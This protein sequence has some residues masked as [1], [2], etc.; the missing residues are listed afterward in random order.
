MAAQENPEKRKLHMV[1]IQ[2]AWPEWMDL[3]TLSRYCCASTRTLRE[4]VNL[5]DNPLPA[6]RIRGKLFVLKSD[7]D[8]WMAAHPAGPEQNIDDIVNEVISS[9]TGGK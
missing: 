3:A 7:F 8:S 4:W 5:L 1:A 6:R 2:S 9:V